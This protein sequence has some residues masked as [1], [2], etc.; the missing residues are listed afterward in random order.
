MKRATIHV[1]ALHYYCTTVFCS[2]VATNTGTVKLYVRICWKCVLFRGWCVGGRRGLY[3]VYEDTSP[4]V[5]KQV[6]AVGGEKFM[7]FNP[8]TVLR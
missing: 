1:K 5:D 6:L 2:L 8:L 7:L 3:E 4:G